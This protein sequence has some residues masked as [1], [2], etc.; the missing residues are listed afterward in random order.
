MEN[1]QELNIVTNR[2]LFISPSVSAGLEVEPKISDF[3][4]STILGTGSFGKVYLSK[5]K[6]TSAI[7]AIKEI[8][9]TNKNNDL[10]APYFR[11]E[12]EIMYK[13]KHPNIVKLYGHFEDEKACYFIMEYIPKGNLFNL[14]TKQKSLC[15]DS[16][17]VANLMKDLISSVYYI[18]NMIPPIIHRDIKPENIL[19]ADDGRLKLTDFGWSNYDEFYTIRSTFCGTPLYLAPEVINK[20]GHDKSV[21][22]WCIG[23]IIFQLLTGKYPFNGQ[24]ENVLYDNILRNKIDWPKDINLE[25]KNLISRILKTDPK[26]RITL[27]DM[28]KHPFFTK[29]VENPEEFMFKPYEIP[30]KFEKIFIISKDTPNLTY[31]ENVKKKESDLLINDLSNINTNKIL[32]KI[33]SP[34][35]NLKNLDDDILNLNNNNNN[36]I[37]NNLVENKNEHQQL[38]EALSKIKKMEKEKEEFLIKEKFFISEK[39]NLI[40]EKEEQENEKLILQLDMAKAKHTIFELD[41]KIKNLMIVL[42]TNDSQI[43]NDKVFMDKLKNEIINIRKIK[44]EA[45]NSYLKKIKTLEESLYESNLKIQNQIENDITYFRQSLIGFCDSNENKNKIP[46]NK[47][48]E[49]PFEIKNPSSDFNFLNT[50]EMLQK[51]FGEERSKYQLLLKNKEDEILRLNI[52]MDNIIQNEL[53]NLKDMCEKYKNEITIKNNEINFLNSKNSNLNDKFNKFLK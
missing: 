29:N 25:A 6:I 48:E 50:I 7:F 24:S 43:N 28:L 45:I 34:P 26:D 30:Y 42:K 3:E 22:I 53:Y 18:H 20:N 32:D 52:D 16:E 46:K 37:K 27:Q 10:G 47:N 15:F 51:D 13:I 4:I 1:K 17:K 49:L 44:D 41:E 21:D 38:N 31:S 23:A 19:I 11:R 35:I 8:D 2:F 39:E 40:K 33:N 36:L 14:L 9:K 5:H 12:I